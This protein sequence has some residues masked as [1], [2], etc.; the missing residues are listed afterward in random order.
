FE[1]ERVT[2]KNVLTQI[3][4]KAK[5]N[6]AYNPLELDINKQ[7]S[8]K[9]KQQKL[10]SVISELSKQASTKYH[11]SGETIMLQPV[12]SIS[13]V[14]SKNQISNLNGKVRDT[15]GV[16]IAGVV[17]VNTTKNRS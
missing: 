10:E 16:A 8:L 7:I 4:N 6:F 5:V 17:V 1:W 11:I 3:E 15:D 9:I 14:E 12:V 2:L 13:K